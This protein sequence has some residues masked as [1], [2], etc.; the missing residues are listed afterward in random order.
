MESLR[1]AIEGCIAAWSHAGEVLDG[2]LVLEFVL[3]DAGVEVAAV[4]DVDN[5]PELV[6]TC[7]ATAVWDAEW[8]R[9]AERT[10]VRYPFEVTPD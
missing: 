4:V 5:L 2:R 6:G 9:P 7:F 8:P 10:T 1:P 3:T